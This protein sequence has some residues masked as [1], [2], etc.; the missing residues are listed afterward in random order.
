ME[1][2]NPAITQ[3]TYTRH[4][5]MA[6]LCGLRRP[7][8]RRFYTAITHHIIGHHLFYRNLVV[9][10][11]YLLE[12][13]QT[14]LI[15]RVRPCGQFHAHLCFECKLLAP[16]APP[17]CPMPPTMF[18]VVFVSRGGGWLW[19][20]WPAIIESVRFESF[21]TPPFSLNIC[22]GFHQGHFSAISTVSNVIPSVHESMAISVHVERVGAFWR[23]FRHYHSD[24][25]HWHDSFCLSADVKDRLSLLL[26]IIWHQDESFH[27]FKAWAI[28]NGIF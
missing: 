13:S 11:R 8:S 1:Q 27:S 7:P 12:A 9:L 6:E 18:P 28:N 26:E 21:P 14:L 2:E 19:W 25:I 22:I 20:I 3:T 10:H 5:T 24:P 16:A 4:H 23:S 17:S 15:V